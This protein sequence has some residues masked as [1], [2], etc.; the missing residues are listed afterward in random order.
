MWA[1]LIKV[2]GH[3]TLSH[4]VS[5]LCTSHLQ[6]LLFWLFP[7]LHSLLPLPPSS[8]HAPPL[9]LGFSFPCFPAP[10]FRVQE[11]QPQTI[12]VH[13][14]ESPRHQ[15][16]ARVTLDYLA[17]HSFVEVTLVTHVRE[18]ITGATARTV[19]GAY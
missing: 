9:Q 1:P 14:N 6:Q 8:S 7:S 11:Q 12:H 13:Y 5:F 10:S 19:T 2:M 17:H 15:W 18:G 3:Y 4:E 16:Q